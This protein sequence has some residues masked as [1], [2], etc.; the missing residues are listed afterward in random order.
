MSRN[1]E[2]RTDVTKCDEEEREGREKYCNFT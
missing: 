1:I 2:R